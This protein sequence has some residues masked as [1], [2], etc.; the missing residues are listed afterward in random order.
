MPRNPSE[1]FDE[2]RSRMHP[3]AEESKRVG[4]DQDSD[5]PRT[6]VRGRS[7]KDCK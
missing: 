2:S 7:A 6:A 3:G 5:A 1:V 4:H